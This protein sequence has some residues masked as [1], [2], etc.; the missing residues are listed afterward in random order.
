[1]L[2]HSVMRI[3]GK[4]TRGKNLEPLNLDGHPSVMGIGESGPNTGLMRGEWDWRV[5][6][7]YEAAGVTFGFTP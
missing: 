3:T 7:H 5:Q 6:D 1:M 4:F 2:A